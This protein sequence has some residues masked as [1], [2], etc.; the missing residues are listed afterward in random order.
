MIFSGSNSAW[1]EKNI[2][3]STGFFGRIS[4]RIHLKELPLHECQ[5]FWGNQAIAPFEKFKLLSVIGGIPRY[6]EEMQI[7]KCAEDNIRRMCFREN[8]LL[9]NEFEEIF[10]DIFT[11]KSERY[12]QIVKIL[13]D[14]KATLS[15]IAEAL[16]RKTAGD[17]SECVDDLCKS[18]FVSRDYAWKIK[19]G[20]E[21]RIS[22]FRLKDNY[23]RFYLKYIEPNRKKIQ[24]GGKI[25]VLPNW[26]IILGFQFENLVLNNLSSIYKLLKISPYDIV[27]AGPFLQTKTK[28][29]E[30][31]QIDLLIQTKHHNLYVCEIKFKGSEINN[32]I[33]P[34]VQEKIKRF[35]RP[36]GFSVRAVLIHVNG[37]ADSVS[38]QDYFAKTIAFDQLLAI[39]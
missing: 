38:E 33:I 10:S 37:I 28:S 13:A 6:L 21:S 15:E 7:N 17:I 36:K 20:K 35:E 19:D 23:L 18:D 32:S 39:S 24:S 4:L 12:K 16:N 29:R 31:C 2:L 30:K 11:S 22:V 26:S 9:F 1:I 5:K 8:G 14:K 34:E 3:N 27:S 25:S